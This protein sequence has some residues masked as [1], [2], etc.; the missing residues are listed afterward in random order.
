MDLYIATRSDCEVIVKTGRSSD[1]RARCTALQA[2]QG[3]W[4]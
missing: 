1:A 3:F 4:V 2:S